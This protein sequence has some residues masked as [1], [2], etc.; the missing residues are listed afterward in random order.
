MKFS[1]DDAIRHHDEYQA[2]EKLKPI[3]GG[4]EEKLSAKQAIELEMHLKTHRY[5]YV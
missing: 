5:L 4:F 1:T 2:F 3:T